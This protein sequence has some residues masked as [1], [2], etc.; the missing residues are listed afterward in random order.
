MMTANAFLDSP[1]EN[2]NCW[3]TDKPRP[4]PPARPGHGGVPEVSGV[5]A[6]RRILL[7]ED[8]RSIRNLVEDSLRSAGYHCVAVADRQQGLRLA[9]A[10]A[11]DVVL[12]DLMLP[13]VDGVTICRAIRHRGPNREVP[14][15]MLTARREESEK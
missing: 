9:T 6:P 2:P 4:E 13:N 3:M 15:L 11:F 14:I 8:E 10:E 1:S 7:V 5:E 12:L